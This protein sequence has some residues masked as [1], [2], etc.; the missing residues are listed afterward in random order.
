MR[1][2]FNNVA[3]AIALVLACC[4]GSLMVATVK[5][6]AQEHLFISACVALVG[7]AVYRTVRAVRDRR[8]LRVLADEGWRSVP[9]EQPWPWLPLIEHPD[10]TMV[11]RAWS[12]TVDRLPVTVGELT[13]NEN[14]LVG[15]VKQWRGRGVFVMVELPAPTEPM[16]Q[17]LHR[18]IG[19]SHRLDFPALRAAYEAGE[20]PPWTAADDRLYTFNP[21]PD[22]LR[23]DRIQEAVRRTLLVVRLLDLGPD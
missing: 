6:I 12:R 8:T 1:E 7:F 3:I 5:V 20:I 22:R 21:I 4:A 19:T 23:A 10:R 2:R 11:Y 17:R 16:A 18:T 15:S 13:W 9:A 14:A